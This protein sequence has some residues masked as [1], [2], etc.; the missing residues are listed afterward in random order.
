M[1]LVVPKVFGW[2]CCAKD[3][4]IFAMF[5]QEL[6]LTSASKFHTPVARRATGRSPERPSVMENWRLDVG[7]TTHQ[8]NNPPSL[9]ATHSSY[10]SLGA[11]EVLCS[12]RQISGRRV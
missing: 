4:F 6:L 7:S 9:L 5:M 12:S 3:K 1:F 10:D 8:L 11:L 2:K